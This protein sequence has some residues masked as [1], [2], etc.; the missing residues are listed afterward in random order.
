MKF[1]VAIICVWSIRTAQADNRIVLESYTGGKSSAAEDQLRPLREE[2]LRK[3][4][5]GGYDVVGRSFES[6]V[7]K[8]A[9]VEGLP[10]DFT[11]KVEAGA[12]AFFAGKFDD[13]VSALGPL[14]DLARRNGGAF[15]QNQDA[16][17]A[18]EKAMIILALSQQRRGDPGAMQTTFAE[19]I[20][21]FPKAEVQRGIYG[22]EAAASFEQARK[23]VAGGGTGT[24]VVQ[25]TIQG[26]LIY[27]DEHVRQPGK[28]QV[29]V[30]VGEHRV[31]VLADGQ[32]SRVHRVTVRARESSV[33]TIDPTYDRVVQTSTNWTGLA[34][35][36][37]AERERSEVDHA[38][39][40]AV[41][42]EATA[43]ALIGV[44]QV[45]GKP[46][47]VGI[48][49]NRTRSTEIRRASIPLD[50]EPTVDRMVALAEFL[51]GETTTPE[52]VDITVL[53]AP[54]GDGVGNNPGG[55]GS[56]GGGKGWGGWKLITGTLA[57][58]ALGVG[59]YLIA[60]DGDC[61]TDPP[62][63]VVCPDV[64]NNAAPGY[65]ALA[66]GVVLAGVTVYLFVRG[67]ST[68]AKTAFVVPTNGG[69]VATFVGRF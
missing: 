19:Y 9:I 52:G 10:K 21:S 15:A 33:I 66:G 67:G 63:G 27:L 18:L 49:V 41:A 62:A 59:G 2:L 6:K 17:G 47:I 50:P 7:S 12:K 20:R 42:V 40:F 55:P 25:S 30:P 45:R 58:G 68:R 23:T 3:G 53:D 14:V 65:A 69:A 29:E 8:P 34:F 54:K 43:V 36:T 11:Q 24:L 39:R 48:L 51:A 37:A 5:L 28:L 1:L 60:T 57:L 61:K 4:F 64:Y 16:L 26:G 56:D 13:A 38:A 22:T 31:F 46:S 32:L 44:D 35:A